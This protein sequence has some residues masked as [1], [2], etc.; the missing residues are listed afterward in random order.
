ML[1]SPSVASTNHVPVRG[2]VRLRE[3]DG[4]CDARFPAGSASGPFVSQPFDRG[5]GL[6]AIGGRLEQYLDLVGIRRDRD[7]ASRRQLPD[8]VTEGGREHREALYGAHRARSVDDPGQRDRCG[9][10]RF[11][12]SCVQSDPHEGRARVP[13]RRHRLDPHRDRLWAFVR[14][15]PLFEVVHPFLGAHR[16]G[17]DLRAP[18]ASLAGERP[19]ARV[20]V[21]G[22]LIGAARLDPLNRTGRL[23]RELR[24]WR[25]RWKRCRGGEPVPSRRCQVPS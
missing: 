3:R 1:K 8:L 25:M 18:C 17:R 4:A 15:R 7:A 20:G 19:G 11:V 2:G 10:G 14:A 22:D 6:R 21:E 9:C 12:V 16:L 5:E 24:R 23:A 13:R